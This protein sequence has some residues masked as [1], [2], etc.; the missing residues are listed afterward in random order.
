VPASP[1]T[2]MASAA[3]VFATAKPPPSVP[4]VNKNMAEP[5]SGEASQNAITG[6]S[7]TPMTNSAAI[8]GMTPHEQ[9]GESAPMAAANPIISTMRPWKARAIR[10]SAPLALA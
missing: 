6:A 1:I 2:P 9:N 3:T 10:L 5:I 4:A 8:N 7:G